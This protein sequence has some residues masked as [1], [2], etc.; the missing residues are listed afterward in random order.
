MIR[1]LDARVDLGGLLADAEEEGRTV[2]LVEAA[3][4]KQETLERFAEALDFPG[5]FGH[6]LDALYDCLDHLIATSPRPWELVLDHALT[7]RNGDEGGYDGIHLLL[8]DLAL[9]HPAT[10]LTVILR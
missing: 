9:R 2:H 5:W 6:N 4:T 3:P 1:T 7:L 10:N 8:S